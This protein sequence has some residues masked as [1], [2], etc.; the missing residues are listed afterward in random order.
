MFVN[1]LA[2]MS[3]I[4]D[5]PPPTDTFDTRRWS[6]QLEPS[7]SP[8]LVGGAE[9]REPPEE[10]EGLRSYHRKEGEEAASGRS[11]SDRAASLIRK[12]AAQRAEKAG[13][14]PGSGASSEAATSGAGAGAGAR[15][16]A[17]GGGDGGDGAGADIKGML[18]RSPAAQKALRRRRRNSSPGGAGA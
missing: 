18:S 11:A 2:F 3:P 10:G 9:V 7:G 13:S 17:E 15:E 5:R 12:N 6:T 16:K 8:G 4:G 1:P 14:S